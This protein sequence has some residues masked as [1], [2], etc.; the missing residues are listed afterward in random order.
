MKMLK[1]AASESTLNSFHSSREIVDLYQTDFTD[2]GAIVIT[3]AD[4]DQGI[5][6]L[7]KS[8][9]YEIPIFAVVDHE[10]K[11]HPEVYPRLSGLIDLN[12]VTTDFF[13]KQIDAAAA[14]YEQ[15]LLPPFF[16]N[17]TQYVDKG[18]V[19]LSTPGH[20]GGQFFRQSPAGRRFYDFFGETLFRADMASSEVKL[21][22]LLIHEGA[23]CEAQQHA[24]K[25]FNADKTY[26]VLNG[27][28]S[29]NKVVLNALLTRGDLVLFDRN[30]HKSCHHGALLQAGATPVYMETC[31]NP[32]GFIGGVD[33]ASFK[34]DTLRAEI[35]QVMP[36]KAEQKRP[37]RLAIIQLGTYDGCTYN[38]RK[39]IDK[40]GHLCDYILF[41]SA[42]VGYEQFIP[43]M[44]DC[45]PMLLELNE[46]DPGILVTQSVHKLLAGLSQASQI[47]KKDKHIKGQPRYCNH[48]HMNNAFMLHASTSPSYPIFA[49]LDVNAKMHEGKHGHKMWAD[50]VRVAVETRKLIFSAC[51]MIKPFV[52]PMIDGR[53][54]QEHET[55]RIAQ[56][57]RFFKYAPGEKW[58][59][60]EGF[61]EDQY[62]VDPC[63][64]LLTTPGINVESGQYTEFGIPATI[65]CNYLREHGIT[66]EKSDL[67]SILFLITPSSNLTKMQHLVALLARFE[68]LIIQDVPMSEVLP[69]IY[70]AN[71]ERYHGY[72]IRQL[73]QEMHNIYIRHNIKDVQ[74][75]LFRKATMPKV[76]MLPQDAHIQFV[77]DNVDLVPL[78][79][80][81]GR[82]AAEGALPYP[83]GIICIVPGEVWGKAVLDY[84]RTWESVIALLPG[85]APE[86]Q[87]VYAGKTEDG[88]PCIYGHVVKQ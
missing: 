41:D 55:A 49:S 2:V 16:A 27:T 5:L 3:Q 38:A 69:S 22:D 13:G 53:A 84:F 57:L 28:S 88:T 54:W 86:L 67:N 32:F 26:F 21:G 37:F 46:N 80:I 79:Q 31:R 62:F 65:L 61:E 20:N 60:Y 17:M 18:N 50:A 35:R 47:H 70:Q 64:L 68:Q 9:E 29:S 87:G 44:K 23:A 36:E 40:I 14:E 48:K 24:A 66:P 34:E 30:N 75:K 33:A 39:V 45:S 56:D 63:K 12:G 77:R 72:T 73:C 59:A 51:S 8:T 4:I 15:S 78:S 83:P 81:E 76:A 71:A 58:H 85:F 25:V 1:V 43:M 11:L 82:I 42:W 10:Q 74:K 6:E 19:S 52:P 7:I